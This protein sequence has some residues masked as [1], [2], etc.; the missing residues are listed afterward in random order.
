MKKSPLLNELKEKNYRVSMY[1]PDLICD[2]DQMDDF[3]NV[4]KAGLR[5]KSFSGIVKEEI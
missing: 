3:D 4:E 1:E 2:T 5:F